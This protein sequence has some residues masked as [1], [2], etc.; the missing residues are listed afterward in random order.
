M[1]SLI[2]LIIFIITCLNFTSCAG[3][4][5]PFGGD[6]FISEQFKINKEKHSKHISLNFTPT[7]Q[8]YNSPYDMNIEIIDPSFN[9]HTFRYEIV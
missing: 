1:T 3:P 4:T 6:V 8:Y 2:H 9:I 5:N 7:R